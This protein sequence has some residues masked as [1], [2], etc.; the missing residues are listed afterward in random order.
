MGIELAGYVIKP[1]LQALLD[2]RSRAA[3]ERANHSLN[4]R[5]GAVERYGTAR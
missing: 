1:G 4:T 2:E 5:L 3:D